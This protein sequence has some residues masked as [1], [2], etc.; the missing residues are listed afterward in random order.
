MLASFRCM[1]FVYYKFHNRKGVTPQSLL[2]FLSL[3]ARSH[4]I[5]NI[6]ILVKSAFLL[7]Y[8]LYHSVS[9]DIVT[10]FLPFFE[11]V[12]AACLHFSMLRV[13]SWIRNKIYFPCK[14]HSSRIH[15]LNTAFF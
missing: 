2:N 14:L 1:N 6:L 9:I 8:L 7:C 5:C 3:C 4:F 10:D 13:G 15:L 12:V 11:F